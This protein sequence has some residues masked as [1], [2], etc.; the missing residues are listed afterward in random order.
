MGGACSYTRLVTWSVRHRFI[1]LI[2]GLLFSASTGWGFNLLP[3]GFL[4][5][6]DTGA[7]HSQSSCRPARSSPIP[8]R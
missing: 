8:R 1:T 7:R 2:I 4:P 5:A 3:Q 6:Q